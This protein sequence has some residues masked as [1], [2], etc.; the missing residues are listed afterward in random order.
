MNILHQLASE[1]RDNKEGIL[2]PI[3]Y[4]WSPRVMNGNALTKKDLIPLFEAARWAPSSSN[5]QEWHYHYA[6]Q[7]DQTFKIFW[8]FLDDGNRKYCHNAGALMVMTSNTIS[9]YKNY[10]IPSHSFDA[11]ASFEN[12]AIEGVNR[13]LIVHPMGG[14]DK[15]KVRQTLKLQDNVIVEIMIAVGLPGEVEMLK[16]ERV[17]TQRNEIET[18]TTHVETTG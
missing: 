5:N 15:Q 6:L 12:M 8:E 4:R 18:C 9:S 2:D 17:V 13:G 7:T 11:G 3:I 10:N 1:K 16:T 14:F